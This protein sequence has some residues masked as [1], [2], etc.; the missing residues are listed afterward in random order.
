[1]ERL[2]SV[3]GRV[4][5]NYLKINS[6][7]FGNEGHQSH[8]YLQSAQDCYFMEIMVFSSIAFA[9]YNVFFP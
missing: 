1:M 8:K 3:H 5:N 6:R 2:S 7:Q 4:L 9:N